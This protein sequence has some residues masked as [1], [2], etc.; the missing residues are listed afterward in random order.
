[1]ARFEGTNREFKRYVGAQLRVIVQQ[2]T[3]KQKAAVG[4]CE[5]CGAADN[6][7]SAHVQGR[8]R[9][10][11]IDMLLG[12]DDPDGMVSV[13]LAEFEAL[14]KAEHQPL[15][16]AMLILC[17]DCHRAYD[18]GNIRRG[19]PASR[20]GRVISD[21]PVPTDHAGDFL[22][23]TLDPPSPEVFKTQLLSSRKAKLEV[24]YRDG[25]T[26]V[27]PWSAARFSETSNVFGNLRSR[28]E[29]RQGEWQKRGIVK[30]HVRVLG[31]V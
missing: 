20:A 21:A 17:Q 25:T 10:D 15:E 24:T 13:N 8:D 14:F 6:L 5:R 28:P 30:V 9:T 3:K 22:P 4:A 27:R 23:I 12:T 18:S 7:E 1:M 19:R 31:D 11:I 2:L 16:K 26:E 29:F